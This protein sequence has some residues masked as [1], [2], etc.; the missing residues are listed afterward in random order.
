MIMTKYM[1]ILLVA[2]L[3]VTIASPALA[4]CGT[5]P[6]KMSRAAVT[7]KKPAI[8]ALRTAPT[9]QAATVQAARSGLSTELLGG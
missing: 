9:A 7:P 2:A 5:P 8:A 6:A 3:S 1:K 4:R